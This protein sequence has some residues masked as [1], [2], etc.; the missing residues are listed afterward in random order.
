M[1]CYNVYGGQLCITTTSLLQQQNE[2]GLVTTNDSGISLPTSVTKDPT[3]TQFGNLIVQ[4]DSLSSGLASNPT[5]PDNRRRNVNSLL[6]DARNETIRVQQS[7]QPSNIKSF[8]YNTLMSSIGNQY[9]TAM[10]N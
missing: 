4:I 7:N 6:N 2:D 9:R 1:T 8:Y 5:I 3:G 10:L